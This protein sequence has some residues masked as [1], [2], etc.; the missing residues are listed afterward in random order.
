MVVDVAYIYSMEVEYHCKYD[1]LEDP[2]N[3]KPHPKNANMHPAEQIDA[4]CRF[5]RVSGFR[6]PIT[7]SKHSGFIVA[8]HARRAS[9]KRIG[10][11]C[12]VVYQDF[13]SEADEIAYLL[14]DN[15]LAELSITDDD[16]LQ[17]NLDLLDEC[18]FDL[19]DI[20]FDMDIEL[21]F[22]DSGSDAPG[23]GNGTQGDASKPALDEVRVFVLPEKRADFF[24]AMKSFQSEHGESCIRWQ[25]V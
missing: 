16:L 8:G 6:Q 21:G 25:K 24:S 15:H 20:G 1:K 22:G 13:D 19:S 9:A 17:S 12:P 7:V 4:L 3:L 18:G 5:I 11:Q 10:C 14:A 2:D 23:S